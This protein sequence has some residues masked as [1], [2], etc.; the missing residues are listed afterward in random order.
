M[1][2]VSLAFNT[3]DP[4]LISSF[5]D[6]LSP[7]FLLTFQTAPP[8]APLVL[9]CKGSPGFSTISP[10]AG[11]PSVQGKWGLLPTLDSPGIVGMHHVSLLPLLSSQNPCSPRGCSLISMAATTIWVG[12]IPIR[13]PE[14]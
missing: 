11:S 1:L 9:A 13:D 8:P 3:V 4:S 14:S 6:T 10:T 7:G 5:Y 2:D 12:M